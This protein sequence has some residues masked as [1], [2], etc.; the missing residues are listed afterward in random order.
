MD[1]RSSVAPAGAGRAVTLLRGLGAEEL[2]H[3]GGTLLAHC[4]RVQERLG[5][6]GARPALQL[7]G[8]CHAFYGTDGFP[9]ALLPLER[10]P[11]LAALIGIEA[12]SLVYLY[13]G[14]DRRATYPALPSEDGAFRDRFT[15]QTFV[16]SPRRRRD[17]AELT[18]A[19]ELDIAAS[20]PAL[21]ARWSHD[22]LALFTRLRPLLTD[23]AWRDCRTLLT[24][25][26][27]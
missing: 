21:H 22:L 12:E 13:A 15:G 20:D 4:Q 25:T 11:Q 6:W 24:P 3:P 7:A 19:N 10:R 26:A 5:R 14:C 23:P 1:G 9:T 18:A 2:K 16:P 17:F 8:L 27:R